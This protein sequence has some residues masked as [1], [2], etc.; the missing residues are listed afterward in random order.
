MLEEV[1]LFKL[2]FV[3]IDNTQ[4]RALQLCS[5]LP[6]RIRI[7]PFHSH[8]ILDPSNYFL[9]ISQVRLMLLADFAHQ[10]YQ[11][12]HYL[13]GFVSCATWRKDALVSLSCALKFAR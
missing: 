1:R 12:H 7:S 8:S 6:N 11:A 13:S 9:L 10:M 3:H 4:T 5:V 2:I